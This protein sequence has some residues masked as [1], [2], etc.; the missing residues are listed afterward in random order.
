MPMNP[1]ERNCWRICVSC[2]KCSEKGKYA[3]CGS[4]SGRFDPGPALKF[5]PYDR[6]QY[7]DC[8]NGILRHRLQTGQLV[9]KKFLTNPYAGKVVTDAVS[10]DEEEWNR[11]IAERREALN[12]EHWDPLRFHDGQS[13]DEWA[14]R[15]WDGTVE[16]D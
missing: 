15:W 7:C 12:D 14:K 5:D 6:D 9:M 13:I 16:R 3:K 2:F 4:C 11:Y 8:R 10:E 1:A